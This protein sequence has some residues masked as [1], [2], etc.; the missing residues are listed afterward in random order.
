VRIACLIVAAGQGTRL[1]KQWAGTPKA[2]VPVLGRPMLYYSLHAMDLIPEFQD[3]VVAVPKEAIAK[4]QKDIKTWAFSRPIKVVAGGAERSESVKNGLEA[5]AESKPD[6]V[7][8]H[9]A[10]RACITKD[11]IEAALKAGALDMAATLAHPEP[12]T[13]RLVDTGFI[14]GEIDRE[15]IA[16]LETPQ[17]FPYEKLLELHRGAGAHELF[18]D[19]TTLFHRAGGKVRV[20]YHEG[21]NMKITYPEDVFAS[22]GILFGRGWQ[23]A[24]EG[25]D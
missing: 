16:G 11:M 2:L 14:S 18:S 4:F 9:D 21:S 22:D 23:D 3:F 19:D 1:G 7:L 13:V 10:A 20:V 25:D 8:I 17:V 5:L 15:K 6:I 12:D 24:S